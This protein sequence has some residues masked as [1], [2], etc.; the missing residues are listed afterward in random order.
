MLLEPIQILTREEYEY[1][2]NRGFEPLIDKRFALY[3]P[4]RIE[5]QRELFGRGVFG[6]DTTLANQ[7]FFRWVWAHK[8]HYC[9]ETMR[10][11][12]YY[13]ATFIS[14]ILSRG[15]HPDMAVDPR[16][17]NILCAEMHEKWENGKRKE[18]RIYPGNARTIELLKKEYQL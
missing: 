4:L 13:S 2:V 11:L 14:H 18:M 15:A 3:H 10:P 8:K 9:E 16:N 6:Y 17:V 1:S 5:I 7:N 12:H